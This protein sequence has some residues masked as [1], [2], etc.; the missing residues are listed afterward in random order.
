MTKSDN[1]KL[2]LNAFCT[3]HQ[4]LQNFLFVVH[5]FIL[6]IINKQQLIKH[7]FGVSKY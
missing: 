3:F 1:L 5:N 4:T 7:L 6:I 2:R